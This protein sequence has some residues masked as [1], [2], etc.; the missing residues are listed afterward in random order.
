M[1]PKRILGRL[2]KVVV[3]SVDCFRQKRRVRRKMFSE[4]R[5]YTPEASS[6]VNEH[7]GCPLSSCS[8]TSRE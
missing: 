1:V 4:K 2:I 5:F 3:T 6:R 7:Q 8:L